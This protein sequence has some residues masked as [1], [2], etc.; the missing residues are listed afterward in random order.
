MSHI[1]M[2]E[3]LQILLQDI[4]NIKSM[5]VDIHHHLARSYDQQDMHHTGEKTITLAWSYVDPAEH[6]RFVKWLQGD[7]K[8]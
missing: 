5:N 6:E 4:N 2:A 8:Q 7:E 3:V 1:D